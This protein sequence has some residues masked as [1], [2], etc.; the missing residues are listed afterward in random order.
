ML[1]EELA[2]LRDSPP[3]S[4]TDLHETVPAVVSLARPLAATHQVS[5]QFTPEE[6]L[7]LLAADPVA[8]RQILLSLLNVAITQPASGGQVR[9]TAHS[10][11]WEVAIGVTCAMAAVQS[12]A[13]GAEEKASLEMAGRLAGLCGG[14]LA[15]GAGDARFEATLTL[16]ALE[17]LP[18]LA[19]DDN[20]GTLQLMQRYAANTR[21]R[22]IG[23]RDPEQALELALKH[24][25]RI[26]VLDVMMPRVDGWEI[27]GRLREHPDTGHIPIIVCTIMVQERLALSLGARGFLRKP[28]TRQAF[29]E[30]L[31]RQVAPAAPE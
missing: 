5:V 6:P 15:I 27:L 17:Q 13:W 24:S 21:Y 12:P 3:E 18:V 10:Q 31:D 19:I 16:P 28:F 9:V 22:L 7:P 30:A 26:V 2:W 1:N 8:V 11:A 14:K 25:P 20:E 4:P 23:T 29:L